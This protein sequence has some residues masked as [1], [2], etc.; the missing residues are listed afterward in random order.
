MASDMA[1]DGEI[2][3]FNE[4]QVGMYLAIYKGTM[5]KVKTCKFETTLT[6]V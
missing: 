6:K 4:Y 5:K 2:A 1:L 3:C